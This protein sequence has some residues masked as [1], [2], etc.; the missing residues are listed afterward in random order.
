MAGSESLSQQ[1]SMEG[2]G[3]CKQSRTGENGRMSEKEKM[4]FLSKGMRHV[5]VLTGKL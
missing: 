3:S 2:R 1:E 4:F 5:S